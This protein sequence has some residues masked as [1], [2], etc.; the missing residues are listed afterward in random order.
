MG[1]YALFALY[2]VAAYVLIGLLFKQLWDRHDDRAIQ[3]KWRERERLLDRPSVRAFG[4]EILAQRPRPAGTQEG[5]FQRGL[6][7]GNAETF[8]RVLFI[9]AR[10]Q[11]ELVGF[12]HTDFAAEEA[13]GFIEV[14]LDRRQSPDW[15]GVPPRETNG[16]REPR[17]NRIVSTNLREMGCAL[18]RQP[19]L[20]PEAALART[21]LHDPVPLSR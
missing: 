15:Q 13:E 20:P 18:V 17:R 1:T 11:R 8:A 2:A 6:Q 5:A 12:L 16:R 21:H 7:T 14:L 3:E 10:D 9:V 4:H 19:A